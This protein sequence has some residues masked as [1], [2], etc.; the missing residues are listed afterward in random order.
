MEEEKAG[1][2][3]IWGRFSRTRWARLSLRLAVSGWI[4]LLAVAFYALG[5]APPGPDEVRM[6][7][8]KHDVV[9]LL[10]GVVGTAQAGALASG[11]AGLFSPSW[12]R[13]AIAVVLAVAAGLALVAPHVMG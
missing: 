2:G 1:K 12:K 9:E 6:M 11:V 3:R 7:A 10:L 8:A 13:A 5:D 4:A